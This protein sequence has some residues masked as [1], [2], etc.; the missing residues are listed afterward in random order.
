MVSVAQLIDQEAFVGRLQNFLTAH[1][2]ACGVVQAQIGYQPLERAEGYLHR[3]DLLRILNE[4][5]TIFV[6]IK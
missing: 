2:A 1:P 5:N 4:L 3:Q 6:L